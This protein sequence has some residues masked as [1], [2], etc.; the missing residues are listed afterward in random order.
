MTISTCEY[1]GFFLSAYSTKT[2]PTH[3]DPYASGSRKFSSIVR[4][5]SLPPVLI[6]PQRYATVITD[7]SPTSS[8]E[9]MDLAMQFGKNI[10]D[11]TVN[12]EKL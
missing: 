9:A 10:I 12:G 11:G 6:R 3:H 2:F 4:I 1:K 8:R 5:D 7:T